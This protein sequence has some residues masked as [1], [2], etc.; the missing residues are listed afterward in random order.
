MVLF[1]KHCDCE[2]ATRIQY[3]PSTFSKFL[4]MKEGSGDVS[5]GGQEKDGPQDT[6]EYTVGIWLSFTIWWCY[7]PQIYCV[8][9]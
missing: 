7:G 4:F 5:N 3:K 6:K 8:T 1:C 9:N 2:H